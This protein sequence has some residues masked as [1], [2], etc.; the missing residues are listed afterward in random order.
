[1]TECNSAFGEIVGGEFQSDFIARQNA[2]AIAAEP[3]REVSQHHTL[4]FQLN[5]E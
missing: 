5:A 1:M 2:D 3:T 4:M